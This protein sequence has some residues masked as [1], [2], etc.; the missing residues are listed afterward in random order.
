MFLAASNFDS[1]VWLYS[2]GVNAFSLGR[3]LSNG[4]FSHKAGI[5]KV[6]LRLLHPF[7]LIALV[8]HSLVYCHRGVMC[9]VQV[10]VIVGFDQDLHMTINLLGC[11]VFVW[12]FLVLFV[13]IWHSFYLFP[14][15]KIYFLG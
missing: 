15:A 8:Q 6:L 5:P 9:A 12:L 2:Y 7:G 10:K 11:C 1:A 13:Y 14:I 3:P 4:F